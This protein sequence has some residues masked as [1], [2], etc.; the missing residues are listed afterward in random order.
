M[1]TAGGSTQPAGICRPPPEARRC[2][3]TPRATA[4]PRAGTRSW[5]EVSRGSGDTPSSPTNQ[6]ARGCHARA[7]GEVWHSGRTR[8]VLY[9][10]R[11]GD[12][13]LEN[14][15]VLPCEGRPE[16]P[17]DRQAFEDRW[18][19]AARR[20][21]RTVS[22]DTG[23]AAGLFLRRFR[24]GR[25]RSARRRNIAPINRA[26]AGSRTSGAPAW[27][28]PHRSAG[29]E[30]GDVQIGRH[31]CKWL[32]HASSTATVPSAS[33]VAVVEGWVS[34]TGESMPIRGT[35]GAGLTLGRT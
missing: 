28:S 6:A 12:T 33:R 2:G 4:R 5:Y 29:L 23:Q 18:Q 10:V 25:G 20:I 22:G 15:P 13:R 11:R 24:E 34:R 8:G 21:R 9:E 16:V 26:P 31:Q 14:H 7:A 35:L 32:I 3:R 30:T 19:P 17:G 1:S 27:G